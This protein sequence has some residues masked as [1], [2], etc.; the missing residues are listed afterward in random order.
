MNAH[1]L[2][3]RPIDRVRPLIRTRQIREFTDEPVDEAGRV[4]TACG[5]PIDEDVLESRE[6]RRGERTCPACWAKR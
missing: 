4:L 6:L 2:P 1:T 5:S 3:S